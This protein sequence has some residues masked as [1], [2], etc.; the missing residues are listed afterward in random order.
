MIIYDVHEKVF[1]SGVSATLTQIREKYWIIKGRQSI[2]STITVIYS[3]NAKTFKRSN[4][5]LKT[6]WSLIKHPTIARYFASN[7]IKGQFNVEKAPWCGGFYE[8][9]VRNVKTALRKVLGKSS[10]NRD[11]LEATI[12]EI[13]GVINS[14]PL[15]YMYNE[16]NKP[17]LLTPAHLL[18]GKRIL[19]IPSVKLPC[20][21][22]L[23]TRSD[24]HEV[25]SKLE[26]RIRRSVKAVVHA[27]I[28]IDGVLNLDEIPDE[29]TPPYD[30]IISIQCLEVPCA[31][32][33]SFVD[34]LKRLN[35][36][37]RKGGGIIMSSFYE[38]DKW[39]IGAKQ[40]PNLKISLKNILKALDM[41]GFGYHDVKSF[42]AL[43]ATKPPQHGGSYFLVSEKL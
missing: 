37:L 24:V 1:H 14:I 4:L 27:D 22:H 7:N 36:L 18:V 42:S 2:K 9:L 38:C 41:A 13:E 6:I 5:D 21:S 10:F 26:G 12:I 25:I 3:D 30:L 20:D 23:S 29:A 8:R 35:K 40:F 28:L 33:G 34:V 15:T 31:N 11:Q 43:H 17:F 32:F 39:Y 16:L 19:S